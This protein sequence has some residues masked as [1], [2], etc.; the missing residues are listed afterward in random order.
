MQDFTS[1]LQKSSR[2][3]S[4]IVEKLDNKERDMLN[5]LDELNQNITRLKNRDN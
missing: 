5:S 1:Q 3:L 4:N 2:V